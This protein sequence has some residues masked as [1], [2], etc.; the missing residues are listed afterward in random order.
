MEIN[1]ATAVFQVFFLKYHRTTPKKLRWQRKNPPFEDAFPIENGG[2]SNV[3]LVFAG[4]TRRK[5]EWNTQTLDKNRWIFG[6]FWGMFFF[7]LGGGCVQVCC[8][9]FYP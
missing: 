2:F 3:M 5:Q 4:V 8:A 6:I 9:L 1:V 7:F